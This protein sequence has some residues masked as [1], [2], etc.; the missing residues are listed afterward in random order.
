MSR[1]SWLNVDYD[2]AGSGGDIFNLQVSADD[3]RTWWVLMTPTYGPGWGAGSNGG[4]SW[5]FSFF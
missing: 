1:I 5:P 4:L 3:R 2:V